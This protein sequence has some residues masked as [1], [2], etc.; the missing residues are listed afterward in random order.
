MP[1]LPEGARYDVDL[2]AHLPER[3]QQLRRPH[4]RAGPRLGVDGQRAVE[5][6]APRFSHRTHF[7]A[8]RRSEC[9]GMNVLNER[10]ASLPTR[11]AEFVATYGLAAVVLC[12]PLEFTSVLVRQQLSRFVLVIVA[13]AFV[14]LVV[15]G[16][17]RPVFPRFLSVYLL[18]AYIAVSLMSWLLTRA[19]GSAGSLLDIA[20]YPFVALLAANLAVSERDHR[21]VWIAFLASALAVALLGGFLYATHLQVWTPHRAGGWACWGLSS[22]PP[23]FRSGPPPPPW[24]AA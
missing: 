10:Q 11:A 12:L 20:L 16:R 9:W 5:D 21:R 1:P 14:Y 4:P 15:T 19:P 8:G 7:Q 6:D 3:L 24:R 2:V 18:L 17:R 13:A 22:P 23:I